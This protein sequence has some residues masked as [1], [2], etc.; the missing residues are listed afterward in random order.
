MSKELSKLRVIQDFDATLMS[1]EP[2]KRVRFRIGDEVVL[3]RQD[4]GHDIFARV[5]N[6][7]PQEDFI[8]ADLA[9]KT[10]VMDK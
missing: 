8:T 10:T 3:L 1:T 2:P 4:G 7:Q 5:S 9:S 6:P